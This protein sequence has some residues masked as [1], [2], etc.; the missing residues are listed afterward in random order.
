MTLSVAE[1]LGVA[2]RLGSLDVGKEATFIVTDGDPLEIRTRIERAWLAGTEVDLE[3][4]RQKQLYE[5]YN[6]RPRPSS[7]H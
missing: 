5:K 7:S 6:N 4:D 3:A 2:D 1:V